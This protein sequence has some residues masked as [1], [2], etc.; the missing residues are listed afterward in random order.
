MDILLWFIKVLLVFL[1]LLGFIANTLG[2]YLLFHCKSR[3]NIHRIILTFSSALTLMLILHSLITGV[4]QLDSLKKQMETVLHINRTISAGVFITYYFAIAVLTIDRLICLVY[5]VKYKFSKSKTKIVLAAF[6]GCCAL[7][8]LSLFPFLWYSF[9]KAKSIYDR[10][11]LLPVDIIVFVTGLVTYIYI[12]R[13]TNNNLQLAPSNQQL[14]S[15]C[16]RV[17]LLI[18]ITFISFVIIPDFILIYHQYAKE[19]TNEVLLHILYFLWVLN[20]ISD[21]IIYIHLRPD[22]HRAF[23]KKILR[24]PSI[25]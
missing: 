5:P 20:Y 18:T 1:L 4:C 19:S 21:P 17:S 2:I 25:T 9:D 22:V 12:F 14:K 24:Y 3:E 15:K 6:A 8:A 7:G 10:Y 11:I 13:I 16:I 23:K